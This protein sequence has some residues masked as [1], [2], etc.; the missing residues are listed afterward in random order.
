LLGSRNYVRTAVFSPDAGRLLATVGGDGNIIFWNTASH[1][2]E[3]TIRSG[4]DAQFTAAT[5]SADGR[6]LAAGDNKGVSWLWDLRQHQTD[7]AGLL[8][9]LD[10]AL[11][12]RFPNFE[13]YINALVFNRQGSLLAVADTK[14]VTRLWKTTAAGADAKPLT[15]I[16]A[17]SETP[18]NALA[19][20]PAGTWLAMARADSIVQ[21]RQVDGPEPVSVELSFED[22]NAPVKAVSSGS[23]PAINT[24]LFSPDGHW[25]AA[26][27]ADGSV[28]LWNFDRLI[29]NGRLRAGASLR[30]DIKLRGS[31]F[32]NAL[33]FITAKNS[34]QA[35]WM[36]TAGANGFVQL[37]NFQKV[38]NDLQD[39]PEAPE[40]VVLG[41]DLPINAVAFNTAS[42]LLVTA[43]ADASI[44][45]WKLTFGTIPDTAG[46]SA[47]GTRRQTMI[48]L[49]C[50]AVSRNLSD[51]EW[52]EY[53]DD[54]SRHQTCRLP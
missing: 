50:S 38:T 3:H 10:P 14:G 9:T 39:H 52:S 24:V 36:V 45:L 6:W 48:D 27:G 2:I 21:L 23:K 18:V 31:A 34:S 17:E 33:A 32:V 30:Q 28:R 41:H 51:A 25:L 4:S 35:D 22:P 8:P 42:S 20:N 19:F 37:W 49:G 40:R 29:K 5:F 1:V 44:R 47:R 54:L 26:G 16:Y 13:V 15:S 46:G 43:S 7:S 12:S 11:A 53:M